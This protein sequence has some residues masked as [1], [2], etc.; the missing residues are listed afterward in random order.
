MEMIFTDRPAETA[1]K[2]MSDTRPWALRPLSL[3]DLLSVTGVIDS[4]IHAWEVAERVR[5]LCVCR[6]IATLSMI[7]TFSMWWLPRQ[8][9]PV[10]RVA[11]SGAA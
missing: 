9:V 1:E 11:L 4:A 6:C 3:I 2:T 8:R 7:L 10:W 5:R